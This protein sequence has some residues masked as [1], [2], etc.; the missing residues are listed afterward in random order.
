MTN[1]GV[2]YVARGADPNWKKR[3]VRFAKSWMDHPPGIDCKLYV[4]FKE[5]AS[6]ADIELAQGM[7][8]PLQPREIMDFIGYNSN[9]AGC[10]LEAAELMPEPLFCP[11]NCS[12]EIMHADW[13]LK[14]YEAFR[15]PTIGLVGTTGSYGCITQV[16]PEHSYP[17]VHIRGHAFLIERVIHQEIARHFDFQKPDVYGGFKQGY[18][19]YEFGPRSMTRRIMEM[20]KTVLVVENDR[21]RAP[22]EWG[23]TTYR[24]NMHNVLVHDRGSRDFQDL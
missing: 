15:Q 18:F 22:H 7:L 21:V 2:L 16:F 12:S 10:F 5:F 1:I 24:N 6:L 19:E 4:T 8:A 3:F 17:N 23:D 11:L 9:G 14:L 20:G 13:L